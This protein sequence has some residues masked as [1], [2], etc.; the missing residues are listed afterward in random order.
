LPAICFASTAE[1]AVAKLG[2]LGATT[3]TVPEYGEELQQRQHNFATA[4]KSAYS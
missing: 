4:S 1:E 2:W 3:K